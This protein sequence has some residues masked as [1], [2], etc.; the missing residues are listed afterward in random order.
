MTIEDF[1][2]ELKTINKDLAIRPNNV[3]KKI[4]DMFPDA[5]N[6]ATITYQGADICTIPNHNIYDEKNGS[7]GIDLR[8]DGR[9]IAHR[10]RPEAIQIVIEKLQMLKNDPEYAD[11]FFGRGEYSDAAL[12]KID[13]PVTELVDVVESEAAEITN[14]LIGG[15]NND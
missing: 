5:N 3:A 15:S 8:A 2:K 13:K 4:L 12:A 14:N 11:Q 1:E 7:Y 6:I 9:F 10:T